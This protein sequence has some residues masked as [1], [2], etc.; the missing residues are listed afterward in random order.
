MPPRHTAEPAS[1]PDTT[2]DAFAK[3][4]GDNDARF[5]RIRDAEPDLATELRLAL[6]FRFSGE[7]PERAQ[8]P[9]RAL[10]LS[11]PAE[12]TGRKFEL[13]A[14][15]IRRPLYWRIA[16]PTYETIRITR[17]ALSGCG[18]L[19]AKDLRA[20]IEEGE[21]ADAREQALGVYLFCRRNQTHGPAPCEDWEEAFVTDPVLHHAAIGYGLC[22]HSAHAVLGLCKVL[23]L[24]ARVRGVGG[25]TFPEVFYDG[26]WHI[27]D[28]NGQTWYPDPNATER[29]LGLDDLPG[30]SDDA[31]NDFHFRPL[32]RRKR[33]EHLFARLRDP[34]LHRTVADSRTWPERA[35]PTLT[36]TLLPRE[37][38]ILHYTHCVPWSVSEA[39]ALWLPPFMPP[40]NARLVTFR[41][42]LDAASLEREASRDEETRAFV[43]RQPLERGWPLQD[44]VVHAACSEGQPPEVNLRAEEH[45][46][47][48]FEPV[49][50]ED[51]TVS[52]Q[53]RRGLQDPD[54]DHASLALELVFDE[55][56][57]PTALEIAAQHQYSVYFFPQPLPG[58]NHLTLSAIATDGRL[59]PVDVEL[60]LGRAEPNA[61]F[62]CPVEP[63]GVVIVRDGLLFRW[64]GGKEPA[65]DRE[66]D[67]DLLPDPIEARGLRDDRHGIAYELMVT[68]S[69]RPFDLV[70]PALHCYTW[71]RFRRIRDRGLRHLMAGG[72]YH[73]RV[74]AVDWTR[75]PLSHWSAFERF[76]VE[77]DSQGG[78]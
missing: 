12:Q 3:L 70:T 54:L 25:H 60:G 2:A 44:V 36:L 8:I 53:L 24:D 27:I 51:G 49:A 33:R 13:D 19:S 40:E 28:P 77:P 21:P 62:P 29:L 78:K 16:N 68:R 67:G 71:T 52:W 23:G 69:P 50:A 20:W 39:D 61:G 34:T 5:S 63:R 10:P 73:W 6:G 45:V 7:L 55:A 35:E 76:V 37:E 15:A 26:A 42:S 47:G 14:N 1:G 57:A 75:K 46:I 43:W 74:R 48:P 22:G 17:F 18:W 66:D 4:R 38:A 30:L 9:G 41:R 65:P 31:W 59:V 64:D 32:G 58:D 72:T 11:I 56:S